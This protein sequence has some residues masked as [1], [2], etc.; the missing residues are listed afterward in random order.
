M[1]IFNKGARD[2]LFHGIRIVPDKFTEIPDEHGEAARKLLVD[3]PNELV[4]GEDASADVKAM[5]SANVE[6][7]REIKTLRAQVEKL[8]KLLAGVDENAEVEIQRKRAQDAEAQVVVLMAKIEAISK[9][10]ANPV[11]DVPQTDPLAPATETAGTTEMEEPAT[12]RPS[13]KHHK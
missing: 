10:E 12:R 6:K 3:Y 9:G 7:D 4:A 2:F 8:Q 5:A 13:R 11:L 1:K